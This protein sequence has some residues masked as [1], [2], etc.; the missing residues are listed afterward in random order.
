MLDLAGAAW[1]FDRSKMMLQRLNR[2]TSFS[3][4]RESAS[5]YVNARQARE[6]LRVAPGI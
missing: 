3:R 6:V 2:Q 1:V 5:S 4:N